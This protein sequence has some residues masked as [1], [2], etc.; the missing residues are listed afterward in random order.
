MCFDSWQLV[1]GDWWMMLCFSRE[2]DRLI[3]RPINRLTDYSNPLT[4]GTTIFDQKTSTRPS[5]LRGG[6]SYILMVHKT[7]GSAAVHNRHTGL[8]R[9]Q[10]S[11]LMLLQNR[12]WG[13]TRTDNEPPFRMKALVDPT[14]HTIKPRELPSNSKLHFQ[15][16]I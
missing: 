4:N 5:P 15:V 16:S 9:T 6:V 10:Y 2:T 8:Q 7:R 3:D 11:K 14:C 13:T 1:I 12:W